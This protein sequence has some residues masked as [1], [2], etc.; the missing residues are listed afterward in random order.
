M[1]DKQVEDNL[2][3]FIEVMNKEM[4]GKIHVDEQGNRWRFHNGKWYG[5][6]HVEPIS[7]E[8]DLQEVIDDE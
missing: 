5:M 1:V 8:G 6:C 3:L 4:E 7:F 2:E